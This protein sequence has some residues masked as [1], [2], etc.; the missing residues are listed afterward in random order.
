MDRIRNFW[1]VDRTRQ[2]K[3]KAATDAPPPPV[4]PDTMKLKSLA[5]ENSQTLLQ[6]K[7]RITL[8]KV[9]IKGG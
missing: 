2:R 5:Y 9:S 3:P 6:Y 1:R 7:K 4:R 8:A